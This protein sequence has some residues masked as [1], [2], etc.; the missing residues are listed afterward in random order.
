MQQ[1]KAIIINNVLLLLLVR[2]L[3]ETCSNSACLPKVLT[4]LEQLLLTDDKPEMTKQIHAIL[5]QPPPFP[6]CSSLKGD[7]IGQTGLR[8]SGAGQVAFPEEQK[9]FSAQTRQSNLVF[10]KEKC[11]HSDNVRKLQVPEV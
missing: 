8:P 4:S 2:P 11:T 6:G 3:L 5:G 9:N 7:C 1:E 10:S